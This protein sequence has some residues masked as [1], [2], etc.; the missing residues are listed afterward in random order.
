MLIIFVAILT[1]EARFHKS[2]TYLSGV[3][4]TMPVKEQRQLE[5]TLM[6]IKERQTNDDNSR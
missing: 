3:I 4:D 5:E 1:K 6:Y 2:F